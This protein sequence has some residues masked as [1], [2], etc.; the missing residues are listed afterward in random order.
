[1]LV[2]LTPGVCGAY[3]DVNFSP[4]ECRRGSGAAL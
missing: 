4:A 2:R 3:V 1:V